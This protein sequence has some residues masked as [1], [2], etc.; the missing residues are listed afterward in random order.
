MSLRDLFDAVAEDGAFGGTH[1]PITELPYKLQ[2][3]MSRQTLR[4]CLHW[5]NHPQVSR[6]CSA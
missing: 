2:D 6:T 4:D 3:R 1:D 5:L